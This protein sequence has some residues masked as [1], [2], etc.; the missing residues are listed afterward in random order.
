[1]ARRLFGFIWPPK[2]A[3]DHHDKEVCVVRRDVVE[4]EACPMCSNVLDILITIVNGVE[5]FFI[6]SDCGHKW[7]DTNACLPMQTIARFLNSR[8]EAC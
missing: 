7:T 3:V 4:A 1:M 6:C 8:M 2:G 5:T